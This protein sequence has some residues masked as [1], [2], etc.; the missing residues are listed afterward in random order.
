[1]PA[2]LTYATVTGH[3]PVALYETR[4]AAEAAAKTLTPEDVE[5]LSLNE[6]AGVGALECNDIAIVAFD[7]HGQPTGYELDSTGW[8]KWK[9][10]PLP[11]PASCEL[12]TPQLPGAEDAIDREERAKEKKEPAFNRRRDRG[13]RRLRGEHG[14][15]LIQAGEPSKATTAPA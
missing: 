5:G 7:H 10:D 4:T 12:H 1:M 9:P 13:C 14:R 8:P 11:D 2:L 15:R 3:L 6:W